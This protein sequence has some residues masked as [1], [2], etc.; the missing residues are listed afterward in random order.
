MTDTPLHIPKPCHEN[1]NA[2]SPGE[3]GRHCAVCSKV[4]MD[5][6]AMPTEKVVEFIAAKSSEKICGR[7]RS[8]QVSV[9]VFPQKNFSFSR[10]LKIFLAAVAVVFGST[11][12]TSCYDRRHPQHFQGEIRIFDWK[13]SSAHF[14]SAA[15]SP[16]KNDNFPKGHVNYTHPKTD[17]AKNSANGK[18]Q[19]DP[20]L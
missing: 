17:T 13:E 12:F 15:D 8:D 20:K 2:M 14:A 11:L 18:V 7:F 19:M 3:K 1:W 5:F 16:I 9:P 6:T 4:V 10:K